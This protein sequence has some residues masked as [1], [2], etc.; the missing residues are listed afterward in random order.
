MTSSDFIDRIDHQLHETLCHLLLESGPQTMERLA[1][2]A[3]ARRPDDPVDEDAVSSVVA[4]S[5]LLVPRPTGL[6]DH[7]LSLLEGNVLTHRARAP[8]AGRDDLWLG[9]GVQPLLNI[10]ALHPIPLADGSGEVRRAV[11]G[12]DVLVGPAGWLPDV[13]RF[14]LVGLRIVGQRLVVEKVADDDLPSSAEQL[15][16]REMLSGIYRR[17]ST[18]FGDPYDVDLRPALVAQTVSIAL[19]EDPALFA[20]PLPPID[21]LLHN[22]LEVQVDTEAWRQ[23]AVGQQVESVGMWVDGI[24]TALCGELEAR[25]RKHGMSLAQFIVALLGT[26]A[27]RTPFAEDLEPWESWLPDAG[28]HSTAPLRLHRVDDA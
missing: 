6:V 16:V 1:H 20:D 27:W 24:P 2:L 10:A 3:A 14:E 17:V 7:S 8:L 4:S 26:L 28:R 19:L 15:R 13:R 12:D 22:P 18:L 21:E 5:T 23:I 11:T 25:A 9:S